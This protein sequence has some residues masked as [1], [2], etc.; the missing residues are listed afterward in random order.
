MILKRQELQIAWD[1]AFC[2]VCHIGTTTTLNYPFCISLCFIRKTQIQCEQ[3][4]NN[5][6]RKYLDGLQQG[7][8]PLHCSI[9]YF[10]TNFFLGYLARL[11]SSVAQG[12]NHG[13]NHFLYLV[14]FGLRLKGTSVPAFQFA[15][16]NGRRFKF[17]L[18]CFPVDTVGKLN[19]TVRQRSKTC[20]DLKR[21]CSEVLWLEGAWEKWQLL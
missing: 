11:L 13:V 5:S 16:N 17:H 2:I 10:F 1:M 4:V 14:S 15:W 9:I 12:V 18:T 21:D 7:F 3:P 8:L 6:Y 19:G 20:C